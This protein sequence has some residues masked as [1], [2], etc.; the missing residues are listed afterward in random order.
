MAGDAHGVTS[1]LRQCHDFA[2]QRGWSLGEDYVDNDISAYREVKRPEFERLL[3]DMRAGNVP[4]LIVWH[5]DRLCRRV[6]D[7][8]RVVDA[9]K[10]GGTQIHTLKAGEFDLST[11]SG[12]MVAY[13]VGT[14]AQF[15]ARHA[16]ERQVA[17]QHDRALK[18]LWRGGRA[19]FGYTSLGGG[20]LEI[21]PEE[22]AWLE[23]WY[24]WLLEGDSI[25]AITRRTRTE[26]PEGSDLKKLS[27][28]GLR[29]RMTNPAIAG[30]VKEHGEISGEGQWEPIFDR[31]TFETIV[32]ILRDPARRTSQGNVRKHMGAGAYFCGVCD[33]KMTTHKHGYKPDK[34]R[35]TCRHNHVSVDQEPLDEYISALVI[36][37]LSKPENRLRREDST[38]VD[39]R[40]AGKL[41][42]E[43][44]QLVRRK[45]DLGAAF[46]EGDID[47]AQLAAG[48][49]TLQEKIAAVEKRLG[50]L[51]TRLPLV[52]LMMDA[53]DL[54]ERWRT[55]SA[56][57]KNTV[58][59]TLM[60][61]IVERTEKTGPRPTVPER[62]TIEWK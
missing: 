1:Q 3:N 12:E 15:E 46:A 40:R 29:S 57:R 23:R 10:T 39:T 7:L 37:Y 26:A 14:I 54:E 47:R 16:S 53:D 25:I 2:A 8:S 9:A 38:D 27:N 31:D 45:D 18:G 50:S 13:L 33:G 55:M 48:T 43:L 42:K 36:G 35:Y 11:A 20:R 61:V 17:S 28:Y 4:V 34:R 24:R 19:P 58:I 30:L 6:K 32:A 59:S 21:N 52:D 5:I 49:R 60:K 44:D 41:R 51:R 62:V 22:A 56:E